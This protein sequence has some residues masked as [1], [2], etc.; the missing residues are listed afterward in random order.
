MAKF[1]VGDRVRAVKD[2]PGSFTIGREYV[3]RYFDP[4]EYRLGVQR[5]DK[6]LENGITADYFDPLP[7]AAEAQLAAPLKIEAGKFY[8]TRDGRKVGP[9]EVFSGKGLAASFIGQQAAFTSPDLEANRTGGSYT[10][11]GVWLTSGGESPHDLIAEWRDAPSATD[12]EWVDEPAV[13]PVETE[14][15]TTLHIKFTSDFSE[16]DAAIAV[17]KKK[18]KKLIKLARKAGIEL[19]EAA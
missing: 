8:R 7:V 6:G 3:V 19:R 13:T 5:D 2:Y 1:K 15:D 11:D 4:I 17:R 9:M 14:P 10:A 12:A 16:L 18:L